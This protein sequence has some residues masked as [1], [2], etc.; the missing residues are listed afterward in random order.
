MA[1]KLYTYR[2]N[3]AHDGDLLREELFDSGFTKG[4]DD[5]Q[6]IFQYAVKGVTH[7]ALVNWLIA[8]AGTVAEEVDPR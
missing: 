8:Q 6:M 1:N 2:S 5:E 4:G 3:I 7:I